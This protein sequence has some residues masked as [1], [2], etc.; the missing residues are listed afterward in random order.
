MKYFLQVLWE[1]VQQIPRK[2]TKILHTPSSRSTAA[3]TSTQNKSRILPVFKR[4]RKTF[5]SFLKEESLS[6]SVRRK[7]A[8]DRRK[9]KRKSRYSKLHKRKLLMSFHEDIS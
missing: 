1:I 7:S 2:F 9:T 4:K 8:E 5:H 3:S 6:R